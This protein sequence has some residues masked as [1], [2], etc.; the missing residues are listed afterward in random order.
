MFLYSDVN[1]G[2]VDKAKSMLIKMQPKYT[3]VINM[4]HEVNLIGRKKGTFMTVEID[5][6]LKKQKK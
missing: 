6:E 5:I 2:F 4:I 3:E 1:P